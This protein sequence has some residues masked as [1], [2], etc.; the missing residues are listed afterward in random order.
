MGKELIMKFY[1]MAKRTNLDGFAEIFNVSIDNTPTD[2]YDSILF[3]DTK[4]QAESWTKSKYASEWKGCTFE[5]CE[6]N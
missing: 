2:D 5:I 4:E 6:D 3:F 1:L